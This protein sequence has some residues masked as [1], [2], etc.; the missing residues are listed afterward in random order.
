MQYTRHSGYYQIVILFV[1]L[2]GGMAFL[3]YALKL[4]WNIDLLDK[5]NSRNRLIVG[6]VVFGSLA[7]GMQ[8]ILGG[9]VTKFGRR[10]EVGDDAET[11][12]LVRTANRLKLGAHAANLD[13]AARRERSATKWAGRKKDWQTFVGAG[14]DKIEQREQA[15][16]QAQLRL[17]RAEAEA[18]AARANVAAVPS[19][20]VYLKR[21]KNNRMV[22]RENAMEDPMR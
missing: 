20:A 22:E 7:W 5:K 4:A 16:A 21:L 1:I 9:G 3:Y 2:I 11:A 8:T 19:T 13:D 14:E 12:G 18:A 17:D 10:V 15:L 6:L